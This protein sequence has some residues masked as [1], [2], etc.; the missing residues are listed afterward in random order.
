[1][2]QHCRIQLCPARS[3]LAADKTR[4]ERRRF[5]RRL[6]H[7][8]RDFKGGEKFASFVGGWYSN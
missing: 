8:L 7:V 3:K 6:F 4:K 1:M 5:P 2:K